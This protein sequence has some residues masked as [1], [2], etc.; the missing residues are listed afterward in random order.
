MTTPKAGH[1]AK[2][3]SNSLSSTFIQDAENFIQRGTPDNPVQDFLESSGSKADISALIDRLQTQSLVEGF[4]FSTVGLASALDKIPGLTQKNKN[5]ILAEAEKAKGRITKARASAAENKQI[6]SL[7]AKKSPVEDGLPTA[8]ET[9][10]N[11]IKAALAN[12][13]N[14]SKQPLA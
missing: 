9:Y 11:I 7:M 14:I 6:K 2:S 3:V 8:E 4:E 1:T 10:P 13:R 12:F 5:I